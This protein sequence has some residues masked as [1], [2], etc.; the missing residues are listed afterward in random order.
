A[1]G[2]RAVPPPAD[3]RF[4]RWRE[5]GQAPLPEANPHADPAGP[6]YGRVVCISGELEAMG[7]PAAWERVAEAGGHPAKNVTKKTGVLVAAR[8]D[9]AGK[10]A[11]HRR[12]EAYR[13]RGQ[14]IEIITEAD[15]L[16]RL[17]VSG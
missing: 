2:A 16:A 10:T 1:V 3:D 9:G 14:R 4:A 13:A 15:F 8:G 11:K 12:A 17:A 7:K 6:L 5:A